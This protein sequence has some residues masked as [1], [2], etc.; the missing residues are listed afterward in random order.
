MDWVL[1]IFRTQVIKKKP[2]V[3]P[4]FSGNLS[5]FNDCGLTCTPCHFFG[6]FKAGLTEF[7]GLRNSNSSS[8]I[9]TGGTKNS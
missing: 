9:T 6:I 5:V 1:I 3:Q 2:P 4:V 8:L 7:L